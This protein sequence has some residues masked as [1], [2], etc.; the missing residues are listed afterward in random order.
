MSIVQKR[1][2]DFL[3]N[4]DIVWMGWDDRVGNGWCFQ[5]SCNRE[6]HL[7]F[8]GLLVQACRDLARSL[9]LAGMV[10]DSRHFAETALRL[11]ERLRQVPEWPG[12]FG[13][14]AAANDVN[15]GLVSP[16]GARRLFE[17]ALNDSVNICSWSPFNQHWIL[18]ALGN[19]DKMDHAVASIKLCWGT[20]LT[21]G[22]GCFWEVFSP[23][24][25]AFLED[26]NKAPTMPS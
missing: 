14:H 10:D 15:T 3:E 13:V 22:K 5:N 11:F 6:A 17:S 9:R 25:A 24:W 4:P 2:D 26:G 12:G 7:T 19:A 21:L 1:V 18:R 8:A 20:M 23:E 16:V